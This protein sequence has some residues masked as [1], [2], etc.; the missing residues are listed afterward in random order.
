MMWDWLFCLALE[1]SSPDVQICSL[2][3]GNKRVEKIEICSQYN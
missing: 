1:I 2:I 3:Q